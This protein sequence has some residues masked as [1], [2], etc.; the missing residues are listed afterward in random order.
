MEETAPLEVEAIAVAVMAGFRVLVAKTMVGGEL[1]VHVQPV[2]NP[3]MEAAPVVVE[4][5]IT[6]AVLK[7]DTV[8]TG[9]VV[10]V[11]RPTIC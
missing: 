5:E 8:Q 2:G 3:E 11:V 10:T 4:T 6:L 1:G 7:S 9:P